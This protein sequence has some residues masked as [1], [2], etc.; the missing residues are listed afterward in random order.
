VQWNSWPNENITKN[1][2]KLGVSCRFAAAAPGFSSGVIGERGKALKIKIILLL[3]CITASLLYLPHGQAGWHETLRVAG[4]VQTGIWMA[5]EAEIPN[6]PAGEGENG[7]T[8]GDKNC[9][10]ATGDTG[11]ETGDTTQGDSTPAEPECNQPCPGETESCQPHPEDDPQQGLDSPA[12]VAGPG[13]DS[14]HS[15]PVETGAGSGDGQNGS[16]GAEEES[17]DVGT[18]PGGLAPGEPPEATVDSPSADPQDA[19]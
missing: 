4:G 18:G 15:G 12:E 9:P 5:E 17:G 14:G 3:L 2:P 7:I 6:L 11:S 10:P 1:L 19:E 13:I 8:D 16:P